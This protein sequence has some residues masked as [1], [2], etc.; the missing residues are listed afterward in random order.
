M[1]GA[2]KPELSPPVGASAA[3]PSLA[4]HSTERPVDRSRASLL[5][6]STPNLGDEQ[7]A[8]N[9]LVA[10][11]ETLDWER[12]AEW[13]EAEAKARSDA[14][15]RSRLL[16]AASEVRALLGAR[17]EAQRLAAQAANESPAMPVAAQQARALHHDRGDMSGVL[18]SLQRESESAETAATRAHAQY[19]LS[20]WMRLVQGDQVQAQHWL[21]EAE[22]SDFHDFRAALQRMAH[23]LARDQKP[24]DV[25]FRPDE[26]LGAL[27]HAA[28]QLR[29]LRGAEA[30]GVG[31]QKLAALALLETRR[32]LG[33][34]QL[35]E[36]AEALSQ[37][38]AHPGLQ[39]AARW[40]GLLWRESA[41]RSEN[42]L[43]EMRQLV[44]DAPGPL[45]RRALAARAL[46]EG[47]AEAL[48]EALDDAF[49]VS[50]LSDS[51]IGNTES[52]ARDTAQTAQALRPVFSE[53][54]RAALAALMDQPPGNRA[55]G[56]LR[57]ADLI[58]LR[59]LD[60]AVGRL[61]S[62]ALDLAHTALPIEGEFAL[63]RHAACS[64]SFSEASAHSG[65]PEAGLW[66]KLLELERHREAQDSTA[67]AKALPSLATQ[68]RAS[69]ECHFLAGVCAE[70]TGLWEL[71]RSH[72]QASM[73]SATTREAAVRVQ[74]SHS[75]DS[76]AMFRALA[77]HTSDAG[78][79]SLLLTEA[80]FRLSFDAP[81]LD[82]LAEDAGRA[83][84]ALPFAFQLA[85]VAARMRGDR[86]CVTRW[87]A[88]ERE[89]ARVSGDFALCTIFE[90]AFVAQTDGAL[91]AERLDELTPEGALD[92]ALQHRRERWGNLSSLT[93][94]Q[95]RRRAA[96]L[97]GHRSREY[98]LGE[99]VA[100]CESSGDDAG[101]VSAAREMTGPLAEIW[102]ERLA[103]EPHDLEQLVHRWSCLAR[104]TDDPELACDLY[105]RLARLELGRGAR[106][107][108]LMWHRKRLELDPGSLA[109]LRALEIDSM[110][111]GREADL[112]R[113]AI[114]LLEN[115]A[116][117]DG[118]PYAFL[119]SRLEIHRGA[120]AEAR[121]L[122][123]RASAAA[124]PPL[125]ALRLELA[126]AEDAADDRSLLAVYR[127]LRERANQPLD[128]ATLSL[129][130]AEA[131]ARL[132]QT[133]LARDAIQAAYDIAPDNVV[134]LAARAEILRSNADYAEA[135]EAFET[136]ASVTQSQARQVDALY[137]AALIWL[138]ILGDR[139][140]GMLALQEAAAIDS[141]HAGLLSRLQS[142]QGESEELEGLSELIARHARGV[143]QAE[144]GAEL[145]LESARA[146]TQAG[147]LAAA[148]EILD[149]LL[150]RAPDH[151]EALHA[152]AE[153][154]LRAGEWGAAEQAWQCVVD[155]V[156]A[157]PWHSLAL[158]GLA[159]LYEGEL[160]DP[161]RAVLTYAS[162]LR[163]EPEDL[164]LRRQLIRVLSSLNRNKEAI[165]EQRELLLR[166]G[167]D[168]ERRQCLLEL[169]VFVE[170]DPD[171]RGEAEALLEQAHRTWPESPEVLE[172]E[173]AH[174][175]RV[176]EHGTA[177]VI[178]E[179]ATNAARNA[180]HAG[181]LEPSLL[182]TLEIA[183]RLGGDEATAQAAVVALTAIRGEPQTLPG[184]GPQSG[185]RHLDD[186]L[187]P[188][189]LSSGFLRI[190]YGA[191]AAIERA[192]SLDPRSLEPV[193][194]PDALASEVRSIASAFGLHEVRVL[195]SEHLGCDCSCLP[196][197]P[198]SVVF[199]RSLVEHAN[200]GVRN[201]L[202][203]RAL[204]IAQANAC[205]LS[206]MSPR[207][208]WSSVAGF[209]AC[210][211]PPW[212][213]EGSDAQRLIAARNRIR[214]HVT[215]TPDP[216]LTA[217]TSALTAN[218]VPQAS[219]LGQAIWQWASRVALLGVG[220][221]GTALDALWAAANMGPAMPRGVESRIRWIANAPLAS[222]LVGFSVSE[223]YIEARKRAGLHPSSRA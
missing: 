92:L 132:Q 133:G 189:Q 151:A 39:P 35:S 61:S 152:S 46:R 23:Q 222:D 36:A 125:W 114:A 188:A 175:H 153:T 159:R 158:R 215:A 7:P 197:Q 146:L 6:N 100:L 160:A 201:F 174:Y 72:Y 32:A 119:A 70:R 128:A 117:P 198:A 22:Q 195:M 21:D 112:E 167:S 94:A 49:Y 40:L 69:A 210:F 216:E 209:L 200:V 190:M 126:F 19:S 134:I 95:F 26:E 62:P 211:A 41:G 202:L 105:A 147:D 166:A 124:I 71:A 130:A 67:L 77:A 84:P 194:A 86:P 75:S 139:A 3:P 154:H 44:R 20:E 90:A 13:L 217:L 31:S 168:E 150:R 28:G 115:L 2:N 58:A 157:E 219:E 212:Q 17:S 89:R 137:Q 205:A 178:V 38:E 29:L 1:S 161:A 183:S 78:L 135:A 83:H 24:P 122:A 4:P 55:H 10:R 34:A 173:V 185:Q 93:K 163:H 14:G 98:F 207:E 64:K 186:L 172:A 142:L 57:P 27:R 144:L 103:R 54:E 165:L 136:L 15:S 106:E 79:R 60:A 68:P 51:A 18:A 140:R 56:T 85:E 177:R 148:R 127:T 42:V 156:T 80:L 53:L 97:L 218:L 82:A 110:L 102:V 65:K 143:S 223:A 182:R 203:Y 162:I 11:A 107:L 5:P 221:L 108:A 16:L 181:R 123:A 179:R 196:G 118:M 63:G 91:A 116:E 129:R 220:P 104:D 199:G 33:R 73:S 52:I 155:Q 8:A 47:H 184:A 131:A 45:E 191:G 180:I 214:P 96:P 87:L 149:G 50:A 145:E 88:R 59:P 109:A 30:A 204:K 74:S 43:T 101:A 9:Y 192:Y 171:V 81:E 99:A 187:T 208:V 170:N 169:A 37:L 176:G 206:L 113:V 25:H 12:R 213:A 138:D 121:P 120:F 66:S 111:P 76:A 164:S 48:G 193:P 141:P